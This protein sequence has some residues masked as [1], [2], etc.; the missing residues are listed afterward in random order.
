MLSQLN[1]GKYRKVYFVIA[2]SDTW[3]LTKITDYLKNH[4]KHKVDSMASANIQICYLYRS[5]EVKQSYFTSIFTTLIGAAHSML[6]I[7]KTRPD[8]V[9]TNG[10]G[11]AVPLCYAHFIVSKILRWR[12]EA[13]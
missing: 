1:P 9:V 2:M 12:P 13:K 3:S 6:L 8:L 11:T 10:P 5:R 7:I 4:A